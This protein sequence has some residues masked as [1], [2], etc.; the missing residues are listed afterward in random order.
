VTITKSRFYNNALGIVPNALDGEKFPPAENNVITDNDIFWNNL[1]FHEGK[2]PYKVRSTGV[3]FLAPIGTGLLLLGGRGN[4]VEKNRIYG[5]YLAGVAAIDG[6]L[7]VKNPAA[8]SLDRNTIRE[9]VFGLGGNDLNGR[10]IA[11]DG[12]GSDNCFSLV[13]VGDTEPADKSTFATCTG[14][15]PFSQAARDTLISWTG[16]GALAGWVKHPHAAKPGYKPLEA[17]KP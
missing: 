5:N 8:I 2:A 15:N 7:L 9:N 12:S 1:N 13:G 3:P 14:K 4:L 11:Y 17:F 16:T 6:I 10:D